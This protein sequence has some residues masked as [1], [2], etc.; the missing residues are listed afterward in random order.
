MTK[1]ERAEKLWETGSWWCIECEGPLDKKEEAFLHPQ[2]DNEIVCQD[3]SERCIEDDDVDELYST[4]PLCN[5][6]KCMPGVEHPDST[7]L[8]SI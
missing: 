3:C 4:V 8:F 7:C 1:K 2:Y 5:C 6:K